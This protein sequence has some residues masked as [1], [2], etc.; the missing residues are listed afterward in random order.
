MKSYE[1]KPLGP[2][3]LANL[4]QTDPCITMDESI[5]P[6][7][8]KIQW[9]VSA[10]ADITIHFGGCHRAKIFFG[11]IGKRMKSSGFE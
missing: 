2:P 4:G 6:M 3:M 8:K 1:L 7:A 5:Y 11:I 10:L 9:Q